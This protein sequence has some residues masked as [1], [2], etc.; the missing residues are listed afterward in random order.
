MAAKGGVIMGNEEDNIIKL[1]R[2]GGWLDQLD[3]YIHKQVKMAFSEEKRDL[4]WSHLY[5]VFV[6]V[7]IGLLYAKAT[8]H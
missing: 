7:V 1:H 2:E 4:V 3:D 6:G 5:G 8:L